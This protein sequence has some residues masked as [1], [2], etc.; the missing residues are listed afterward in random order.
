MDTRDCSGYFYPF[1][2]LQLLVPENVTSVCVCVGGEEVGRKAGCNSDLVSCTV[3]L[4][5][6][7]GRALQFIFASQMSESDSGHAD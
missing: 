7:T 3:S 4:S 5:L 6:S 2:S 1:T